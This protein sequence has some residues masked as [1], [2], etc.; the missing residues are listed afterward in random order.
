MACC[1]LA[2]FLLAQCIAT[3]RRWGMFWG[4]VPVPAGEVADTA[5]MRAR[6]WLARP[7]VHLAV[8]AL[9]V[10]ELVGI[11]SWAYVRHG[12]H[13]AQFADMG[14]S[15]LHGERVIYADMCSMKGETS[16]RIVLNDGRHAATDR[17]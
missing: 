6:A 11:G 16:V 14:W 8:A 4:L 17:S 13:I 1:V 5:Y 15:R 9:L 7:R 12:T 2:A 10:A 3:L